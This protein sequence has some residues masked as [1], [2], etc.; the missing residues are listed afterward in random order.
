[1]QRLCDDIHHQEPCRSAWRSWGEG[2]K[3]QKLWIIFVKLTLWWFWPLF[4]QGDRPLQLHAG[5][6]PPLVLPGPDFL[7]AIL[8]NFQ[9]STKKEGSAFNCLIHFVN[10]SYGTPWK[11]DDL[12]SALSLDI[13]YISNELLTDSIYEIEFSLREC[14]WLWNI[15]A[16]SRI[17]LHPCNPLSSPLFILEKKYTIFLWFNITEIDFQ[18]AVPNWSWN[19]FHW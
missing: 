7:T 16:A 4:S 14:T 17:I 15:F 12:A 19:N 10:F 3:V 6:L 5:R 2:H 9:E 1:M 13:K 8:I 11:E 18:G